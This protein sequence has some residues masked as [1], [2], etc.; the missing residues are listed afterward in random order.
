MEVPGEWAQMDA[1]HL[2]DLSAPLF[3][4]LQQQDA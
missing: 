3:E 1:Q 2:R 4:R